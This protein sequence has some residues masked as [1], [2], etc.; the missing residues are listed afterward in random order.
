[1]AKGGDAVKSE[2]GRAASRAL[3]LLVS[4]IVLAV[5]LKIIPAKE[6]F[7]RMR[8]VSPLLWLGV[9]AA[10]IAG[11]AAAAAKWRLLIG[12]GVPYPAALRAHFAGL[13]ANLALPGVAGGDIV[14]AGIVMKDSDR[15]TTL[16]MAS[17]ADRLIDVA[18]LLIISAAG[19]AF[20]GARSGVN[21]AALL[22]A[23]FAVLAVGATGVFSIG[24]IAA[25]I[26]RL[27]PAGKVGDILRKI[28]GAFSELATRR[29][30]FAVCLVASTL[31][32]SAFA[33]L[34]GLIAS[35]IGLVAPIGVWLFA[36]PLAKLVATL[37]IS[38]GGIGVR[39]ASL[40]G[41]MAPLGYPAA[42]VIA[43]SLIWQTIQI[44]GGVL[45]ALFLALKNGGSR[46]RGVAH[47]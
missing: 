43:A 23:A 28:A 15:K 39:E 14:R 12:V 13:A 3:R 35:N 47:G 44:S 1:M 33:S 10:F 42:G 40:A 24:H 38:F 37:P 27:A 29:V 19:A 26:Q 31:I 4:A 41:V 22:A 17:L 18:A 46:N 20:I 21:E 25:L 16:A 8:D 9:F 7:A 30:A 32:Q 5:I 6:V 34:T 36:W 2:K 11:H 45:G